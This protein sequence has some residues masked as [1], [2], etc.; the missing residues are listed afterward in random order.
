MNITYAHRYHAHAQSLSCVWLFVTLWTVAHQAP[1]SIKFS[2]QEYWSKLPFPP[3][4][5][6]QPRDRTRVSCIS[7]GF[8]FFLDQILYFFSF[9]FIIIIFYF[10]IVYWFCHTLTWIHHRCICVP[11]PEPHF[12][13]PPHPIPLGHPS[14]PVPSTLSSC[15]KPGQAICFIYDNIHV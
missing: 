10:T 4:G 7:G 9:Y 6:S 11:H 5:Y 8:F 13:L 15:I 14:A 3:R 1:L 2:G 12:Y